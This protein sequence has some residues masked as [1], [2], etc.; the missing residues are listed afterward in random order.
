M[1]AINGGLV[2]EIIEYL[3]KFK[4]VRKSFIAKQ[5]GV[6]KVTLSRWMKCVTRP[7][8]L[9]EIKY[10]GKLSIIYNEDLYK[11]IIFTHLESNSDCEPGTVSG[12]VA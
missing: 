7:S 12:G 2:K 5:L 10:I 1:F 3:D 4:G 8:P 6:S 9:N 11:R